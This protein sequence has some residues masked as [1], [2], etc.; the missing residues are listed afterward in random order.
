MSLMNCYVNLNVTYAPSR[1]G[2][3][4]CHTYSKKNLIVK[5]NGVWFRLHESCTKIFSNKY[6]KGG[7]WTELL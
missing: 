7:L 4:D 1:V 5:I 2:E 6:L 3:P